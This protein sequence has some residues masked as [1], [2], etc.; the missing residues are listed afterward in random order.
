MIRLMKGK[1]IKSF[2]VYNETYKANLFVVLGGSVHGVKRL[3]AKKF[4][5][6][7]KLEE[8]EDVPSGGFLLTLEV[9]PYA[10]L[11]I[12]ERVGPQETVA[13]IAHEVFHH[14]LRV[15]QQ[16]NIPTYPSIDNFTLDEPAAYLMEFYMRE[17]LNK[18]LR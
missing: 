14:V 2:H 1:P 4:D 16:R 12:S 6:T 11:W 8:D 18:K 17:I 9:W 10:V 5:I 7:D 15:C 3:L 13:K